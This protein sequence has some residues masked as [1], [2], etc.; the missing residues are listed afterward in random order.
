[1]RVIRLFRDWDFTL[2][3]CLL[4]AYLLWVS[5]LGK[6]YEATLGISG[7]LFSTLCGS[8]ATLCGVLLGL[9]LATMT[10][11]TQSSL[12]VKTANTDILSREAIW[13]ES[14]LRNEAPQKEDLR[15]ILVQLHGL[16]QEPFLTTKFKFDKVMDIYKDVKKRVG[17]MLS[18]T[19]TELDEIKKGTENEGEDFADEEHILKLEKKTWRL[20]DLLGHLGIVGSS[21]FRLKM[22]ETANEVKKTP[23]TFGY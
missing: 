6:P 11:I 10:L 16:C 14:W 13:A 8:I 21:L 7:G 20:N 19:K 2:W 23:I 5:L 12:S 4:I 17:N 18:I 22:I 15:E 3:C 1:M 9:V